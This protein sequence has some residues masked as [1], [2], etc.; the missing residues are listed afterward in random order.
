VYVPGVEEEAIRDLSRAR[1][2]VL[3]D[4]GLHPMSWTKCVRVL[5]RTQDPREGEK[6]SCHEAPQ[7]IHHRVQEPGC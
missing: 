6:G 5:G 3:R 7:K 4:L 2:D 1:E